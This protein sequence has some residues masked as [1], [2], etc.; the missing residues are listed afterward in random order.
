RPVAGKSDPH[1]PPEQADSEAKAELS[2]LSAQL[3][4][5]RDGNRFAAPPDAAWL[6]VT[7]GLRAGTDPIELDVAERIAL[8]GP[9]QA[10]GCI[11]WA[12][13]LDGRLSSE[14]IRIGPQRY[15][16]ADLLFQVPTQWTAATLRIE[17]LGQVELAMEPSKLAAGPGDPGPQGSYR[18][19]PPRNLKP[20][21]RD[22]TMAAI[23]QA[24]QVEIQ[25]QPGNQDGQLQVQIPAAGLT[26][27]A[28]PT[29]PGAYELAVSGRAGDLVCRLRYL[30]NNTFILY[31]RD[32][33]F[34]QM[35]FASV[36]IES[37]QQPEPV[38]AIQPQ[39]L[40]PEPEKPGQGDGFEFFGQGGD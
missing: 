32:E 13:G 21:L 15:L 12:T 35:T 7:V 8:I 5:F 20:M 3:S 4:V 39:P 33:P 6:R 29:G 25:F 23:Q 2:I 10:L 36:K 14:A 34:H 40:Q 26:G 37:P 16:A 24:R 9:G 38:E 19:I 27:S 17:D 18:E 30:P 22:K 11:G 28:R 1:R 31:L